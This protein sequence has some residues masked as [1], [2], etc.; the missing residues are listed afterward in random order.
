MSRGEDRF[1][2]QATVLPCPDCACMH[3]HLFMQFTVHRAHAAK[4]V[5]CPNDQIGPSK[6]T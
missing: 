4:D 6:A 5:L 3:L 1:M 2:G